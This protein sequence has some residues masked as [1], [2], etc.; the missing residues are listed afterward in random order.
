MQD[1]QVN[2]HL[3]NS[4]CSY[5]SLL[6]N[7]FTGTSHVEQTQYKMFYLFCDKKGQCIGQRRKITLDNDEERL[8]GRKEKNREIISKGKGEKW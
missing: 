4:R 1:S 2:G 5:L 3:H 8:Q 6:Q 7:I